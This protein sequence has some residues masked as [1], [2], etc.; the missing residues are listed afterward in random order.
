MRKDE[1]EYMES[2]DFFEELFADLTEIKIT[3]NDLLKNKITLINENLDIFVKYKGKVCTVRSIILELYY[4]IEKL[5]VDEIQSEKNNYIS[6]D[7]ASSEMFVLNLFVSI[8]TILI[9]NGTVNAFYFKKAVKQAVWRFKSKRRKIVD[10]EINYM[11]SNDTEENKLESA[12]FCKSEFDVDFFKKF[13][14]IEDLT[15]NEKRVLIYYMQIGCPLKIKQVDFANE[16]NISKN[17][18]SKIF[19]RL[20]VERRKK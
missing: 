5:I 20:K 10:A 9:K 6:Y 15:L 17:S 8:L 3:R 2:H 7:L 16:L 19:K 4:D 18:I 13:F 12:V 14:K 11:I 1:I